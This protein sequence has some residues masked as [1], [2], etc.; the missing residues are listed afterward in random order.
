MDRIKWFYRRY[1][2]EIKISC[3]VAG[4]STAISILAGAILQQSNVRT[5]VD[6][7]LG[8]VV[9]LLL[10]GILFNLKRLLTNFIANI[11]YKL[12]ADKE[13]F[14]SKDKYW[15]RL[16]HFP[17]EKVKIAEVFVNK[18]LP[19]I[20]N[21][22]CKENN[23]IQ[24]LNIIL[25]SGTTITPIFKDL[26]CSGIDLSG[27]DVKYEIFTNNLAGIDEI[28]KIDP[29]A[30][31]LGDREFSLIGGKPLKT[32]RATTGRSTLDFLNTIWAKQ[33]AEKNKD[34]IITLGVLTANWFACGM[35]FEKIA[36]TAKG[37]GHFDFKVNVINN[38]H[39]IILV[40]PLGKLLPIQSDQPL[41]E[42]VP[43]EPELQYKSFVIPD[44]KAS[45]TYLLTSTRPEISLSP[46]AG[47][48]LRLAYLTEHKA[49][50]NYI[51]CEDSPLFD[52]SGDRYEVV[53]TELPHKYIRDNFQ[54]I[55]HERL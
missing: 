5:I 2:A 55:F 9:I 8:A 12:A 30:C 42:L 29:K 17:E 15:S 22:I 51:L 40:S 24:T 53:V 37:E 46:I 32:Y 19:K 18:T 10:L 48:S 4:A 35:G 21:Q 6:I 54:K 20:I 28:Y 27:C 16:K 26:V 36:I 31:K 1:K 41:N 33:N 38:S 7:T 44:E 11:P 52:P 39:Y 14:F 49:R 3:I 23:K 43:E 45:S 34:K 13:T 25:D 50:T 47:T